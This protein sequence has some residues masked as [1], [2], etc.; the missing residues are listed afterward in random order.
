VQA[1]GPRQGHHP[2]DREPGVV[3]R[4]KVRRDCFNKRPV[5]RL[6]HSLNDG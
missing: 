6:T 5:R 4:T 3:A 2:R 1:W